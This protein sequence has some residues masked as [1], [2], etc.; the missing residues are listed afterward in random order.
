MSCEHAHE[1]AAYVLGALAPS[2]RS[3]Y[4]EHLEG[5]AEC[6]QSVRA[7][8][9]LPGLLARVP[10]EVLESARTEEAVPDTLLPALVGQVHRRQRLRTLLVGAAGAAAAVA[11]TVGTVVVG[12]VLASDDTAPSSAAPVASPAPVVATP[13]RALRPLPVSAEVG[14]TS[15]PWGTRLDL[16][17]TYERPRGDAAARP[18]RYALV[19]RTRDGEVEQV[20]T[21]VARPGRTSRIAGA[22]ASRPG[23]IAVVEIRSYDGVP[24]LRLRS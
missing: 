17:C 8:A 10:G 13:M 1:D 12:H 18:W 9:G 20:A 3:A 4:R 15:V 2:E 23:Q 22:T 24:L 7:L 16:T 6:A 5:C 11:V 19:V 14:L 21:W